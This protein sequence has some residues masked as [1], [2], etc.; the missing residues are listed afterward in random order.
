[1]PTLTVTKNYS[2]GTVLTKAQLDSAFTS[3]ETFVNTTKLDSTNLQ[4]GAVTASAIASGAVGSSQIASSAISIAALAADVLAFLVPTGTI[5]SYGAET[6]PSG[7][8]VCDGS[9]VSRSTYA[10]LFNVIGDKHG[11]GDGSTTFNLPDHR[12]RFLRGW[13]HG[14]GTDPDAASR[15]AMNSG[16]ATG[17]HVG[18]VQGTATALPNNA[19]GT[20][21]PGNHNHAFSIDSGTGANSNG[22]GGSAGLA[23]G[24]GSALS[25]VITSSSGGHVH[26]LT[27][28]DNES[29]PKNA[30]VNYI[31]KI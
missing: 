18:S 4:S 12:G 13:D 1:M 5:L 20:S 27:G 7:Y 24:N 8:L 16:G 30:Y 22:I 2:D 26:T 31:I 3:V 9:A 25:T 11:S 29:R 17:N 28:G 14:S 15:T 19:F 21:N 10:A 23:L 6:S